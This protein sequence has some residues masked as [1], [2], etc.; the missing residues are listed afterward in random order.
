MKYYCITLK[1][2]PERTEHA[3]RQAEKAGIEVD[4]IYGIFGKSMQVKCEIPYGIGPQG[5]VESASGACRGVTCLVLSW[6]IAWQI[7]WREGHEEFVIFED[8]FILPDNFQERWAKLRADIP[9]WCD[10]VYL[11]SCCTDNKLTE[12]ITEELWHLEHPLCTAALWHR[13]RIIPLLQ[14][15][16]QPANGPIDR[17]I[18]WYVLP[19]TKALTVM[20]MLVKQGTHEGTMSSTVGL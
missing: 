20:P 4:F 8:D 5:Q 3:R 13:R 9:D 17:L 6:H 7:A 1:E 2:T 10:F 16:C 15:K 11:N 14:E 12:K 18:E 19:H